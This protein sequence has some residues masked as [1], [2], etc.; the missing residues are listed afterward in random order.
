MWVS[1]D[2]ARA[3]LKVALDEVEALT[4]ELL[5]LKESMQRMLA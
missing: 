3:M 5:E 1:G 2:Q 4:H